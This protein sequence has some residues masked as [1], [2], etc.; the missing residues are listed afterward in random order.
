MS[1]LSKCPKCQSEDIHR[2][3]SR[4]TWEVWRKEITGKRPYRCEN[5][6]HRWWTSDL[7]PRHGDSLRVR[8]DGLLVPEPPNLRGTVLAYGSG[9]REL[10]LTQLDSTERLQQVASDKE[11]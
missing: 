8:H 10:N 11:G 2:S 9:R 5:C 6:D 1:S 7:G 3:R 4:T